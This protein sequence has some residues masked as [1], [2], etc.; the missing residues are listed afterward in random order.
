LD[1]VGLAGV[2][3]RLFLLFFFLILYLVFCILLFLVLLV[4]LLL[5]LLFTVKRPAINLYKEELIDARG[6]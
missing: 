3:H 5:R 1:V 2:A 6:S 4:I